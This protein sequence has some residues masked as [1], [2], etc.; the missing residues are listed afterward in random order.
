MFHSIL[1]ALDGRS[2]S[3]HAIHE[4]VDVA[5]MEHAKV[6]ALFVIEHHLAVGDA[7]LALSEDRMFRSFVH[8]QGENELKHA[9]KLFDQYGIDGQTVLMDAS[10]E[11]VPDVICRMI[12]SMSVDLVAMGRHNTGALERLFSRSTADK[13]LDNTRIPVILFGDDSLPSAVEEASPPASR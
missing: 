2:A 1:V 8:E 11:S 12:S 5:R 6:T 4:V 7:V 13:V 9:Q 10:G 3:R